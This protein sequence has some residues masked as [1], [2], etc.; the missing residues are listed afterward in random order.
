M[1]S[2]D[3]AKAP[4]LWRLRELTSGSALEGVAAFPTHP[5][6]AQLQ[7]VH[8]SLH[9]GVTAIDALCPVGRGQS[10]LLTGPEGCSKSSI[11]RDVLLA[12]RAG[13]VRCVLAL[14]APDSEEQ[15]RE[16]EEAGLLNDCTV[17]LPS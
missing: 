11:A 13:D 6:Q 5:E 17:V 9:T 4:K 14:T 3:I 12:Q 10:M 8:Q 1:G 16:L 15:L 2:A 7:R